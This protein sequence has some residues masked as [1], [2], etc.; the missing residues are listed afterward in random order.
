MQV[1]VDDLVWDRE[2]Y[3][4]EHT[5]TT[6][7]QQYQ[8]ALEVGAIFPPIQIEQLKN[9]P[10]REKEVVKSI[11]D[12]Y[13]RW[14]ACKNAKREIIDAEFWTDQV[15]DYSDR[16]IRCQL[17]AQSAFYNKIH[18]DRTSESDKKT[19]AQ[20]IAENDPEHT[21]TEQAIA[22][23]VGSKQQAVHNWISDIRS[24]QTANRDS[25]ILRLSRLG[26]T[27]SA[28]ADVVGISQ[29]RVSEIIGNTEFGIIDNFLQERTDDADSLIQKATEEYCIDVPLAWS[30][31][32]D[33]LSDMDR[34]GF[35][36]SNDNAKNLK[37]GPY[38]YDFWNFATCDQR[39]GDAWPGRIPA[40]IVGQVL[41]FYTEQDDLV[42]DPMAGGGVVPDVCLALNRKCRAFDSVPGTAPE[43]A[44]TR[45]EIEAWHWDLKDPQWPDMKAPKLIFW[46][47]PYFDK[48]DAEYR[49]VNKDN[50]PISALPK[51]DYLAF[52]LA[53]FKLAREH[54]H[55][56]GMLALL[57][58]DW[59]DEDTGDGIFLWDYAQLLQQ[60]GWKIIRH[61]QA[62]LSTQ[63][64]HG[65][66]VNKFRESKRLARLER[67]LL[68][69]KGK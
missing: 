16:A 55:A 61:I 53:W 49:E 67:Y 25:T 40:Q 24:K 35:A 2:T 54:I 46:D 59:N 4:R 3:A 5:S 11:R 42:M 41:Y 52:F 10:G 18:G 26:W 20:Y 6:T 68:I 32:M 56:D 8:A 1:K 14:S 38:P 33:G 50:L 27:Q 7:A 23:M 19:T 62:P 47:P 44:H 57:M 63:S 58:C 29:N 43:R 30:I 28:I 17:K 48:K 13:H 36:P 34:F 60:T 65:D 22:D 21:W 39:F 31:R 12:G 64:V 51:E 69:A 15:L 37:W 9:Y 66:F 45:P